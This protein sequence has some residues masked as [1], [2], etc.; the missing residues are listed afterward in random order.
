MKLLLFLFIFG[1]LFSSHIPSTLSQDEWELISP[2]ILP[3]IHPVKPVLDQI[4][5]QDRPIRNLDA[6]KKAGFKIITEGHWSDTIIATHNR[7][8]G[9][10]FKMFTE[11]QSH[12]YEIPRLMARIK[13]ALV[14]QELVHKYKLH[15]RFKVPRKWLY[16][17]SDDDHPDPYI[18]PKRMILVTE[19]MNL[20]P[21]KENYRRWASPKL[22]VKLLESVFLILTEGGFSDSSY[23]FNLPFSK[24]GRIALIDND[25]FNKRPI[26]F[27]K[28]L[29]YLSPNRQKR[30][31]Q[32]IEQAGPFVAY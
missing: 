24:D 28:L 7:A 6:L 10:F 22:D 2:Y 12:I 27:S 8:K 13:G 30:A 19:D 17:L 1:R 32:L 29:K 14:A 21:K 18:P 20:L 26:P 9:Y 15:K 3:N 25:K 23:A 5:S 4:F 16:L 11:E 31:E